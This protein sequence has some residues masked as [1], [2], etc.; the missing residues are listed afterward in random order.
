MIV[1]GGYDHN[2]T[3]QYYRGYSP[4]AVIN[5]VFEVHYKQQ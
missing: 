5:I 3:E 1:R 4:E 2:Y